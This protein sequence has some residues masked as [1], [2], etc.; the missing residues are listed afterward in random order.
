MSDRLIIERWNQ[1]SAPWIQAVREG[2]ID[3]RI[4]VTDAA[5]QYG[6]SSKT[7]Y[8][9]LRVGVV[10]GNRNLIFD[11]NHLKKGLEQA[12]RVLGKLTAESQRPKG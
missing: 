1:N 5:S 2:R 12:Y 10:D 8:V 4:K 9:W 3:S 11:N 6:I 7:I